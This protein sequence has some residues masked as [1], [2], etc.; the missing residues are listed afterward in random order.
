MTES[1][2]RVRPFLGAVVVPVVCVVAGV[3]GWLLGWHLGVDNAVYRSGAVALL[4]GEPLYDRM[5]LSGE[6]SWARLPFTYPPTAAV[7]FVPLALV[8]TQ[9][10][11]GILAAVSV[12]LLGVVIRVCVA[13]L[14]E[15]PQWM[16]PTRTAVVL[17][18][19]LL[20]LEP[21]WR[22]VFLGQINIVLMAMVVVD[23]LVVG[24]R[25]SRFGG[26]LIG[27]AAAVKLTPLVFVGHLLLK[28]RW[29]DAGRAVGTFL[30][31]QGLV[32]LLIR[33][34]FTQ[35]WWH[36]VQ[37]PQRIGP[38]YWAGNQSLNGL[39]LRLTDN[40]DWSMKVVAPIALLIAVPCAL[41]IRRLSPLPALLV[42]AF[43]GLLVSPVSWSHHWVWAVPLVVYLLS[44][45]PDRDPSRK[46]LAPAVAVVLVFASCVLLAMRN[47]KAVEFDWT[48]L[49]YVI[50]SAYLLVPLV[51]GAILLARRR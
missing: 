20:G 33:H 38:I 15:R 5:F 31:L 16:D 27:A 18:V 21:V 28:K 39:V 49:E 9:V 47:G 2:V 34:D 26:V 45:L 29:A 42:T 23:V 8:P 36:A 43:F 12:L 4:Q 19:V 6:P 41:W 40:A 3:V 51:A 14:P 48:V 22:T 46:Q 24:A 32:F 37:D 7:F 25:G 10:A 11:W 50:G 44:R 1:V 30:V 13:A 35:F 17:G